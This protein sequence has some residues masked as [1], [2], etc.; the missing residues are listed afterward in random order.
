MPAIREPAGGGRIFDLGQADVAPQTRRRR[1]TGPCWIRRPGPQ[2]KIEE[3]GNAGEAAMAAIGMRVH[4]GLRFI[5]GWD[6]DGSPDNAVPAPAKAFHD[7]GFPPF[8]CIDGAGDTARERAGDGAARR[9]RIVIGSPQQRTGTG[10]EENRAGGFLIELA[11]IAGERLTGGKV[12]SEGGRWRTV[13]YRRV[14]R[15]AVSAGADQKG[16][17]AERKSCVFHGIS[18]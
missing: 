4:I 7:D 8:A 9:I 17:E 3:G 13:Q 10:T 6:R 5:P 15:T 16:Q 12:G 18:P 14:V 11:L 2:G 1:Q